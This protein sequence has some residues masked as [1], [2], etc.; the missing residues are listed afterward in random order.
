MMNSIAL[1]HAWGIRQLPGCHKS[2]QGYFEVLAAMEVPIQCNICLEE[3][4]AM[5]DVGEINCPHAFCWTCIQRWSETENRFVRRPFQ[6]V[7][8]CHI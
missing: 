8:A 5:Q 6:C 1:T 4:Q 2:H 3:E 7:A